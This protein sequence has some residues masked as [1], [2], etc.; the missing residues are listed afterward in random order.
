MSF[1]GGW[2]CLLLAIVLRAGG[3]FAE[4]ASS[5][6]LL[7]A[8]P[9]PSGAV[10]FEEDWA[11]QLAGALGLGETLS[12]QPR[13]ADVFSLL[14][15]EQAE[16]ALAAGGR[17][18][19]ADAAFR[20]AVDAPRRRSPH[21]PVRLVVSLPA[22][23]L[24]QLSVEGVGLQRWVVDQRPVGHVDAS[25]LGVVQA[26]VLI[27]LEAGPHEVTAYLTPS[28]RV[29]RVE[30]AAVR[31]LCAAPADGW[32]QGRPLRHG[33]L[34]RSIVRAFDFE[35]RLQQLSSE[36]RKIEAEAFDEVSGEGGV[37]TR[38]LASEASGGAWTAALAG[39]AEFTW[40]LDLEEPRV[41]SLRA[42]THGVQ[43]QIWSIDGRYRAS[44]QPDNVG[45]DFTW[46]HVI[47]VPLS[48]G[49]HALR[50]LLARGS[51]VDELHVVPHRSSDSDYVAVLE[52]LGLPGGA[53][54]APVRRS[55]TER[56]LANP[57][58]EEL[59]A[60]FRMRL[61]GDTS[62]R[63]MALVNDEPDPFTSRSLS[64]LLPAEL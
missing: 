28:A 8:E 44:V 63:S 13:I 9:T 23:A 7:G 34:A 48:S 24:Y 22:T 6:G 10:L 62:N 19:P 1:W 41:V 14:C 26:P 61:A 16:L 27:P 54:E 25:P 47:T 59:A 5:L 57:A 18:L 37:T 17:S 2:C 42:R 45:S 3:A 46:N 36:E 29:D 33:A 20:V 60:G 32:H 15:V 64:P 21:G 56:M 53:P 4:P 55:E 31:T 58:F 11:G 43:P 51:G 35:R 39:P 49:R 52:G 12:E 40:V 50:A 30:I 38:R